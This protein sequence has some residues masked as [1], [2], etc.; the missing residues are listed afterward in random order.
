MATPEVRLLVMSHGN[1]VC[2]APAVALYQAA[3]SLYR[4]DPCSAGRASPL[5][6]RAQ[7]VGSRHEDLARERAQVAPNSASSTL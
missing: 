3:D 1:P 2:E 5:R 7:P 6:H 4:V